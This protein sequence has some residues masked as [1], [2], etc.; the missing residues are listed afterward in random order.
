MDTPIARLAPT[1]RP[2]AKRLS[3][4]EKSQQTRVALMRSAAATVGEQGYAD[5]QVSTITR[6]AK[7]AQGTFY[8]YFESKQ[9]LFDQLLPELGKELLD[10]IRDKTA[11]AE[12]AL[13]REERSFRAFFSF[14]EERPEFYRILYE[15]ELFAPHAFQNHMR[16]VAG[17]YVRFLQEAWKKGELNI[18]DESELEP[19][20]YMLM[21]IRHYLCMRYARKGG[22]MVTLPESIV[23][24]YKKMI[25]EGMFPLP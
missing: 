22:E 9:E 23:A 5:T 17:G 20:G 19:A 24:V 6:R 14:L 11:G 7:V 8:N 21:G 12:T 2:R 13:E 3:R 15:A 25:T 4:E 18:K 1:T 16:T 10:F